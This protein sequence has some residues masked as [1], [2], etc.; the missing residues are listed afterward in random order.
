MMRFKKSSQVTHKLNYFV[1][2]TLKL[3]LIVA[4]LLFVQRIA[5][6]QTALEQQCFNA[7]QGKVA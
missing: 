1:A 3:V 5:N 2:K 7:V 6:A 4:A